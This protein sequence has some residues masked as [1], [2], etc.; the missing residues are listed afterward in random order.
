VSEGNNRYLRGIKRPSPELMARIECELARDPA[1]SKSELAR[2]VGVS[3]QTVA[4]YLRALPEHAGLVAAANKDVA[5]TIATA[6]RNLIERALKA[7]DDVEAEIGRLRALPTSAQTSA[8]TFRGF[9]TLERL[10]RLLA[11]L[12]KPAETPQQ[13]LYLNQISVLLNQPV[14]PESLSHAAQAALSGEDDAD[15]PK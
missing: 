2:R 4:Y 7:T 13:N 10:L 5:T 11:E 12:T 8:V 15:G 6:H 9:G 1:M 3:R 14:A